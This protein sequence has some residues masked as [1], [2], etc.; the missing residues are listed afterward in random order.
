MIIFLRQD[1]IN[2]GTSCDYKL[3]LV[4]AGFIKVRFIEVFA[5]RIEFLPLDQDDD[6]MFIEKVNDDC[7][8]E[9]ITGIT[10]EYL[11]IYPLERIQFFPQHLEISLTGAQTR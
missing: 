10:Y 4:E 2:V 5:D 9:P 6:L 7:W 11:F 8:L 1:S 3:T